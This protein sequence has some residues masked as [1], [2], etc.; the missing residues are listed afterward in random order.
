LLQSS[1][2]GFGLLSEYAKL[3]VGISQLRRLLGDWQSEWDDSGEP[4]K[5]LCAV[6]KQTDQDARGLANALWAQAE[7]RQRFLEP[8]RITADANR[9]VFNSVVIPDGADASER[10]SR[11][12]QDR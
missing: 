12:F 11:P 10:G 7:S 8:S 4:H 9:P 6:W 1:S 5:T 3:L 2:A